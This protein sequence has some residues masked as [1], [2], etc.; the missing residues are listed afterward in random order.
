LPDNGSLFHFPWYSFLAFIAYLSSMNSVFPPVDWCLN[1]NVYEVNLRQYTSEGTLDAFRLHLPRL[2]DMGVGV[3]WFMPLTP[4]SKKSRKGSMGSY[5]A[6]SSYTTINPEYGTMEMFRGLVLEAQR[7]GMKVIIDWVANHTGCDHHWTIEHPEYY[8]KDE[9]GDFFDAHGWDDVIDLDYTNPHLRKAMIQ[10][11]RNWLVESGIDGFRCDM[12]MLTPVDFWMEARQALAQDR[13]LFWLAELDPL[14]NPDYMQVFDAAY[15]WRWMNAASAFRNEGS[16]QIH[17]LCY[18]LS[19]YSDVLPPTAC[20]AWFTSNHDENSWNGTEYEKYGEMAIPLAVF[21]ATYKG[22][23]LMYSGQ[24]IPNRKRLQFFDQ[25]PLDWTKSPALHPFYRSILHLR[26]NHA[27][28][29]TVAAATNL[30]QLGNSVDHHVISFKRQ[31]DDSTAIVLINFSA[32][33]L[34]NIEVDLD[35]ATGTFVEHFTSL[36]HECS[37]HSHC[38]HLQPWSYQIWLQ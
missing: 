8:K 14:D 5:Y 34:H 38:F 23:P 35:G 9:N 4:I 30:V 33:P 7:L 32:F 27:A 11:M 28:F 36:A 19:Q 15:T 13:Q 17:H 24:E 2:A 22:I 10:C 21:S 6:C 18:V 3:L 12:A 25:D 29:T 20:P 37:S 1:T 16:K 26:K 31:H